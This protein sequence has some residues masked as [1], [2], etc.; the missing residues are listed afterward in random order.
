MENRISKILIIAFIMLYGLSSCDKADF[1]SMFLSYES[2][3]TRFEQSLNKNIQTGYQSIDVQNDSYQ[4]F[5]MSDSHTGGTENLN[6]FLQDADYNKASAV[7]MVGD[8]T[9]G[10]ENDYDT[11]KDNICQYPTLR[12]FT[13]VG[14]H[15][16]Y[17]NGWSL[18]YERF[19]STSYYFVLNGNDFS[20]IY[21]CLDTGSATLG[22]KQLEWFTNQLETKRHL[23]RHC[24]VFTH[25]NL[26]RARYIPTT[27]PMV[28]ELLV[29]LDLFLEYNVDMVITGHDHKK[30]VSIFGNT[31]H[32]KLD[33][34]LDGYNDAGYLIL[35][36]NNE[37]DYDF[38]NL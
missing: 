33:A 29:L 23:Y 13:M 1:R 34:L 10:R 22:E 16:I 32:I 26:L 3:N 15:D 8:I 25:N 11:L 2:V 38:I 6:S 21:F 4:I 19:G 20:D 12:I 5:V 24:V 17:F 18:Y 28:E 27:K 30:N 35:N 37:L 7:V 14:N 9:T 31:T 36:V